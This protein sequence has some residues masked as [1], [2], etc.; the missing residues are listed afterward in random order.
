[1]EFAIFIK[2][3]IAIGVILGA[4][5]ASQ[6][7]L[8]ASNTKNYAYLQGINKSGEYI[9][10]AGEWASAAI[11]P[12]ASKEGSGEAEEGNSLI[13]SVT[14]EVEKKKNNFLQNSAD[15]TK[16]FIAQKMLHILGVKLED[17]DGC[18]AN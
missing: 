17:L 4:A 5:F 13:S 10:K 8:F 1:M 15:S 2:N 12:G 16:E 6:Q 18:N 3:T 14:E 9:K 7:P 11:Y